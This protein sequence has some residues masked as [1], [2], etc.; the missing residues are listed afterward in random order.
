MLCLRNCCRGNS[1]EGER[2]PGP[3]GPGQWHV[4]PASPCHPSRYP[5]LSL[6]HAGDHGCST[7]RKASKHVPVPQDLSRA[8]ASPESRKPPILREKQQSYTRTVIILQK[9]QR[10]NQRASA[11]AIH[12]AF[13]KQYQLSII[14]PGKR[15]TSSL[16]L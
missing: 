5:S 14:S 7:E 4:T 6:V 3:G 1:S 13:Q 10:Q 8:G 11:H 15:H 9:R 16:I 2:G 12:L